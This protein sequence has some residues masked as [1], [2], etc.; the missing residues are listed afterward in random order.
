M[1]CPEGNKTVTQVHECELLPLLRLLP[2]M[3][4]AVRTGAYVT[5]VRNA[6]DADGKALHF[7]CEVCRIGRE[8]GI[9][10]KARTFVDQL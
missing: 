6:P 8:V 7:G 9:R 2:V 3:Y 5:T 1:R 10:A 4:T